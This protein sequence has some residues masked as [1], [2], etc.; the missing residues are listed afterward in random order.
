MYTP[1]KDIRP[2]CRK[3]WISL[4][5]A[6]ERSLDAMR[7]LNESLADPLPDTTLRSWEWAW[8]TGRA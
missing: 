3:Y 6:K 8:R 2:G 5:W 4:V 7:K 1:R